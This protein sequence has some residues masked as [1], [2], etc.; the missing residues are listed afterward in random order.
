MEA[1][2]H[3]N[4][5]W[6]TTGIYMSKL[7][8]LILGSAAALAAMGS[9][10][11]AADLPV[12]AKG[13]EYVRVC[14]LYGAGFYY[15][16]GTDTCIRIGGY[17]RADVS[18]NSGTYDVPFYSG[19]NA[20]N[21]RLKNDSIARSRIMVQVDTRTATEYGV[22]RTFAAFGPQ[23]TQGTDT[24]GNG[25]IR[26]EAA[27]IQFAGFTFGRSASAY[28]LPWNGFPGNIGSGLFGAPHY[29]GGVNNIQY[30]WQLGNG[31]SA[32]IGVDSQDQVN[33]SQIVNT[34]AGISVLGANGAG[35][36]TA[37]GSNGF[38]AGS[39][40]P[41]IVGSLRF[42]QAWG[43]LQFSG[44]A[45]QVNAVYNGAAGTAE[46]LGHPDDKWGYAFTA[47]LQIK[48]LPTGAGD[49][50]KISGTYANGATRYVFGQDGGLTQSFGVFN[51][52][53]GGAYN[54]I[55]V[56]TLSDAIYSGLPGSNLILTTAYG[57]N[58]AFNHNWNK[59]W[60]TSLFGGWSHVDYNGQA[61]A[62][63]CAAYRAPANTG[64]A[65]LSC[66]P[67]FTVT[68]VGLLQAWKPVQNLTF[69]AEAMWTN[70]G[71][72]ISGTSQAN[73]NPGLGKPVATYN[74]KDQD[75]F[76]GIV[77]VQRNF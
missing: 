15:I 69:S 14:S 3:Q 17:L 13:V 46:S 22:V 51:G 23:F 16:P 30:T 20:A 39:N 66:N 37:P 7:K 49:D 55:A 58:G 68:Q 56:S 24:Q 5:E 26:V 75:I 52:G 33:R 60:T 73:F 18:I 61:S 41:D 71:S 59:F 40:V 2:L 62:L 34:L 27:F 77:R 57:F 65:T 74:L 36:I 48:N 12:K 21:N 31:V 53:S 44:A 4:L 28:A 64:T 9:G 42:E 32:S 43:L 10:A 67:D 38:Y 19:V 8:S 47:G 76:S 35:P 29:G 6:E 72:G 25:S 63:Y 1:A 70:V 11:N 50:V 54:N 45:H